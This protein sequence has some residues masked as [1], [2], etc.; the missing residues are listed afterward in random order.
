MESEEVSATE[1]EAA[2]G[3]V[4]VEIGGESRRLVYDFNALAS[5]EEATGRNMLDGSGWLKPKA[6]DF[7]AF[8]W[9]GLLHDWPEVTLEQV[10]RW[11]SEANLQDV[12][13]AFV[14]ARAA[15]S[16]K[17]A[18]E[19]KAASPANPPKRGSRG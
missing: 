3:G 5:I 17:P 2:R 16:P 7:R 14:R 11:L 1:V 19:G 9:A 6:K 13:A 18:K 15:S 10:G 4:L 8:V 12:A